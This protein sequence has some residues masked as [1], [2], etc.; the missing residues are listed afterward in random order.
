MFHNSKSYVHHCIVHKPLQIYTFSCSFQKNHLLNFR[1]QSALPLVGGCACLI[2]AERCFEATTR[3]LFWAV[4]NDEKWEI[5]L[6]LTSVNGFAFW[7]KI[8][9]LCITEVE[10][11]LEIRVIST[12]FVSKIPFLGAKN[13]LHCFFKVKQPVFYVTYSCAVNRYCRDGE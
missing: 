1:Q 3:T 12:F 8:L 11:A 9:Y 2:T 13:K 5:I 7:S 10:I 4:K 6:V